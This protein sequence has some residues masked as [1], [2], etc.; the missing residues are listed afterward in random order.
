MY[1]PARMLAHPGCTARFSRKLFGDTTADFT[2]HDRPSLVED[3][4]QYHKMTYTHCWVLGDLT[5]V[6][7]QCL[8][9]WFAILACLAGVTNLQSTRNTSHSHALPHQV[10]HRSCTALRNQSTDTKAYN[11]TKL[12]TTTLY[13]FEYMFIFKYVYV[14]NQPLILYAQIFARQL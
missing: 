4:V 6:H 3:S 8:T 12:C 14:F 11:H 7:L 2:Q 10:M 13:T 5:L 1:L 9:C